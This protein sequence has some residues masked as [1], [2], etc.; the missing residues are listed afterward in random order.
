[1]GLFSSIK[2]V[3]KS[4]WMVN[5]I[6]SQIEVNDTNLHI[7]GIKDIHIFYKDI[8]HI[9]ISLNTITLDTGAEEYLI[10]PR[11]LRGA[12]DLSKNLYEQILEKMETAKIVNND[13]S[14]DSNELEKIV[15]MYKEGLLTDEE[16]TIM[17]KKIIEK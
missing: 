4:E 11:K 14:S 7:H 13:A 9:S 15:K 1:M 17:K 8:R 2:E 10:N 6:A 12:K 3:R 16:F 5:K